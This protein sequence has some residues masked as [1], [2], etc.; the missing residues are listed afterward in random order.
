M[1]RELFGEKRPSGAVPV[2]LFQRKRA[3]DHAPETAPPM[4]NEMLRSPGQPLDSE[5]RA[6][7]EPRF[8]YD[9]GRLPV[10]APPVSTGGCPMSLTSPRACPFGGACHTCPSRVQTKLATNQN[11]E[12][13]Q[14]P[15][16]AERI[17][18]E[19]PL[20]PHVSRRDETVPPACGVR[21]ILNESMKSAGRKLDPSA[22]AFFE[23]KFG[24]DFSRV[25]IHDDNHAAESARLFSAQAFTAGQ[26]IIFAAGRYEPCTLVGRRLLGHELAHVVQ[27]SRG[28]ISPKSSSAVANLEAQANLAVSAALADVGMV[29]VSGATANGVQMNTEAY[30]WNPYVDG[31]GHAAIKLCDG[32]YISWWPAGP[33]DKKQQYWS[34]RPGAQHSYAEDVGPA[35]ENK[36]PD[37]TYDLGCNCL[38]E[39]A[40]KDWYEKNFISNPSPK[41][42][43]LRNSC[44]DVV[45]QAINEGSSVTN[46]CYASLS[47]S[48][49]FWT[50]QD[51]GA[52]ADCQSRWCKSKAAGVLNATG[53]YMWEN[54]K[55]VF[56]GAVVNTMKSILWKG[57]IVAKEL[58]D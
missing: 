44:S 6:S 19:Y 43:V 24:C 26:N 15:T 30:V 3:N 23:S 25:R 27:Q 38:D 9:F 50:P 17:S 58:F 21:T 32:A 49:L 45:H 33:G 20:G 35:G 5:T 1:S 48:N 7:M 54:V 57:K 2:G 53:R 4:V 11:E 55:E 52:Y 51:V 8:G 41:W 42:A 56:G 22:E 40:M 13:K 31:F 16:I 14:S 29:N 46:P 37:S 34:G 10:Y 18:S 12:R 39:K 47:H 28:G 36:G